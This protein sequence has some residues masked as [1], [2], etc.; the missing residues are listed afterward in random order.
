MEC[1]LEDKNER[2]V[3]L[4]SWVIAGGNEIFRETLNGRVQIIDFG[5]VGQLRYHVTRIADITGP[6]LQ[7]QL[8]AVRQSSVLRIY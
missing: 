4:W 7:K 5:I 6:E 3:P 1:S 2:P 8:S